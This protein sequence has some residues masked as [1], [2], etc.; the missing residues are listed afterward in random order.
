MGEYSLY[1]MKTVVSTI[2]M[3]R[4]VDLPYQGQYSAFLPSNPRSCDK[5]V[6]KAK[7]R[8]KSRESSGLTT[9]NAWLEDPIFVPL[10]ALGTLG[11]YPEDFLQFMTCVLSFLESF[12]FIVN[13]FLTCSTTKAERPMQPF[14]LLSD[15][16]PACTNDPCKWPSM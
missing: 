10:G 1:S 6:A 2:M 5:L 14:R 9:G 8:K 3:S 15:F 7:K 16:G 11:R 13:Y 12:D 4:G